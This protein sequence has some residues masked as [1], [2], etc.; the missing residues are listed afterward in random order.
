MR[1]AE[2]RVGNL[3]GWRWRYAN[4]KWLRFAHCFPHDSTI[5]LNEIVLVGALRV[6]TID[7][8]PDTELGEFVAISS[9]VLQRALVA[10][11][12][13]PTGLDA[14]ADAIEYAYS[15][16]PRVS[17]MKNPVG[18]LFKVGASHAGRELRAA[19]RQRALVHDPATTNTPLDL[20]LQQALIRLP[21]A[22]RVAILLVHG[23]GHT[24]AEAARIVD[25]P[26]ATITNHINRGLQ[27]LRRILEEQ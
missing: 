15:N 22:Q 7:E 20:D 14:A 3:T 2:G 8:V 5:F 17:T 21:W 6:V 10:R 19:R 9:P 26:V 27:R 18:Y 24:Y 12:G 13:I 4:W 1:T 11:Y 23:H 16:W 25:L